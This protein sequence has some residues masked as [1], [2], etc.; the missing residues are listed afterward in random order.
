MAAPVNLSRWLCRLSTCLRD[1]APHWRQR[2]PRSG[3]VQLLIVPTGLARPFGRHSNGFVLRYSFEI[4]LR[5]SDLCVSSEPIRLARL[6]AP[7]GLARRLCFLRDTLP[8]A[9]RAPADQKILMRGLS[10]LFNVHHPTSAITTKRMEFSARE[11]CVEKRMRIWDEPVGHHS[12]VGREFHNTCKF[13]RIGLG[14]RSI[15]RPR[16]NGATEKVGAQ[17][18]V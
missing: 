14:P 9:V 16:V 12:V 5:S 18:T 6:T 11:S 1:G 3:L 8:K 4:P 10:S 15:E 7:V 2:P 17:D 13:L